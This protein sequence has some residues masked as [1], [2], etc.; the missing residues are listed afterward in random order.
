MVRRGFEVE[1]TQPAQAI[2]KDYL[3]LVK[4]I[5]YLVQWTLLFKSLLDPLQALSNPLIEGEA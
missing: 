2:A 5:L 4:V 1:I 3:L